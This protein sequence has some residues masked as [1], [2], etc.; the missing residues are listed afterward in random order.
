[1]SSLLLTGLLHVF[2]GFDDTGS[3]GVVDV[4]D[5]FLGHG[6]VTDVLGFVLDSLHLLEGGLLGDLERQI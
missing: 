4:T 5:T 6:F 2:P 1:M 3:D